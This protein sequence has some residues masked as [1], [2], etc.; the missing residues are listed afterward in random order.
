MTYGDGGRRVGGA[1]SQQRP[2]GGYAK[3]LPRATLNPD[4][5]RPFW[6][7][8]KKHELWVQ[9]CKNCNKSFFYPR[10][11]CPYDL[12][13]MA[14]LVWTKVSGKGRVYSYT[15][16]F[17]PAIPSFADEAPYIHATI[18]LDEG[19]RMTGNVIGISKEELQKDPA[20]L[21]VNQRVEAVFEDVTPEVTLVK[22]RIV[23]EE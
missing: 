5:S 13:P 1:A 16:V 11:V 21:Q 19:A 10:E 6:E 23:D 3:P 22:W 14:D 4:V 7:G 2:G 20:A 8:T 17:Q 18:Q 15:T 9:Y 12:S